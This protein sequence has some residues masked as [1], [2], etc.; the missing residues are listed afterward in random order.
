MSSNLPFVGCPESVGAFSEQ[1]NKS[2]EQ[3]NKSPQQGN[4]SPEQGNEV[5]SVE[6][7]GV[8]HPGAGNIFSLLTTSRPWG[9]LG[10]W[11]IT[12]EIFMEMS[13]TIVSWS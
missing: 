6:N 3:G 9:G 7:K 5:P 2:P 1:G 11:K 4:K 10:I 8:N 12:S 13:E